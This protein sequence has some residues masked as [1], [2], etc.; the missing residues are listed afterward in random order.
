MER[1]FGAIALAVAAAPCADAQASA[2]DL[3]GPSNPDSSALVTC[4]EGAGECFSVLGFAVS[5]AETIS[6][7]DL[8]PLYEPYLG[9][10]VSTADLARVAQ[11]ITEYYRDRGFFLTRAYVPPQSDDGIARISVV[12]G[13]IVEVVTEGPAA[14]LAAPYV[15]TLSQLPIARLQDV[16]RQLTLAG[17]VPGVD[18]SSRMEAVEGDPSGHR[19]IVTAEFKRV[20]ARLY[21]DNRGIDAAGPVQAYT[22]LGQN[23][24][25]FSRDQL[26]IG[27]FTIPLDPREFTLAQL[28]YSYAFASGDR[29]NLS[30]SM[31]STRDDSGMVVA[32]GENAS[33]SIAYE[34]P[35]IRRRNRGLWL[36][37]SFDL[38]HLESD[39]TG[40]SGYVDELRVARGALRGF[41]DDNGAS[42]TIFLRASAGLDVLGASEAS[43]SRRSRWDADADFVKFDLFA[44]HYRDIGD[45]FGVYAAIAGQWAD[46]PLLHS[47][48]FSVGGPP[49]GRAYSYGELSG[50]RGIAGSIELRAGG[51]PNLDPISFIQGY[52][53]V[54][55]A[56]VWNEGGG[57]ASLASAGAG[58]RLTLNDRVTAAVELARPLDGA[59]AEE[60]NTDWRQFFSLSAT[61]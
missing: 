45:H 57:S 22:W 12:E 24:V 33:M 11:S 54:D 53:F 36:G 6:T 37:A 41:L 27:V 58:V 59:P 60:G 1:A 25:L 28:G 51:D 7:D 10:D 56:N 9:R 4:V 5:G 49:F 35:L 2:M 52:V 47:E 43:L 44:S 55:S 34:R 38:R 39:W 13:R 19:L 40:G 46:Q 14:R 8:L 16:D 31:S 3:R 21:L 29:L 30:A 42:T 32:R 61:Y 48:E 18:V 15:N 17:D 26:S 50:E 23:S 20:E